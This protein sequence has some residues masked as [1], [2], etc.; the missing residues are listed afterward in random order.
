MENPVQNTA[1][2]VKKLDITF[3]DENTITCK[4]QLFENCYFIFVTNIQIARLLI[5]IWMKLI[6][7]YDRE[8]PLN[9]K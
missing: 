6:I 1:S 9:K 3:D 5:S 7:E 2:S 4:K 8:C